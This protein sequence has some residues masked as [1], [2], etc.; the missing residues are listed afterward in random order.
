MA[1]ML[2]T[3]DAGFEAAFARLLDAKRE[4]TAD[5]DAAVAAIIEDVVVRG[6]AALI[7]L[8]QNWIGSHWR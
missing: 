4:T 7:D 6:D 5:V 1:L 3:R 8:P 2:S